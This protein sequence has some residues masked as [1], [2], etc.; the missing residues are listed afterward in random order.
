MFV[1]RK[2]IAIL[3]GF[4]L[5]PFQAGVVPTRTTSIR[6]A[7]RLHLQDTHLDAQLQHFSTISASD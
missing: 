5:E 3:S 7:R 2:R 1:Q 4:R 6:A